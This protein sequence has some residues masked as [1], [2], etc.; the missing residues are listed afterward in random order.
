MT[1]GGNRF[2]QVIPHEDQKL[3]EIIT[4]AIPFRNEINKYEAITAG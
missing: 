2:W 3:E 1:M 4:I